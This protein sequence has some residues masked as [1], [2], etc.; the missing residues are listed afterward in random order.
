MPTPDPTAPF[1]L[2]PAP[3]G[4]GLLFERPSAIIEARTLADVG[5]ALGRARAL[6][7]QGL[8]LAGGLAFEAAPAF[9]PRL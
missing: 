9:E 2:F 7:R 8:H 5:P 3:D 1:A 4:T 6:A